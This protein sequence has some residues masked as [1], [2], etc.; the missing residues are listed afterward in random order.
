[1]A[2]I[3]TS[4]ASVIAAENFITS[5]YDNNGTNLYMAVGKGYGDNPDAATEDTTANGQQVSGQP[6][7]G[8]YDDYNRWEDE[9]NPPTPTDR[10][11]NIKSFLTNMIGMKKIQPANVMLVVPR[12]NWAAGKTYN[13]LQPA[14]I[15]GKR[16]QDYYCLTTS[17]QGDNCVWVCVGKEDTADTTKYEPTLSYLETSDGTLE[18]S[19]ETTQP[20]HSVEDENKGYHYITNNTVKCADG[21][22]WKFLY[23]ITSTMINAGLLLDNWMPVPYSHHGYDSLPSE[24]TTTPSGATTRV[25]G[26]LTDKQVTYG[27]CNANRT[28]GAYRVLV[29]CTLA[30]EGNAI[31]YSSIYR[32][33]GLLVDPRANVTA[34]TPTGKNITVNSDNTITA[35]ANNNAYTTTDTYSTYPQTVM[36]ARLTGEKYAASEVDLRYNDVNDMMANPVQVIYLENKKPMMREESQSEKLEIILV[37]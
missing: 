5:I 37:F 9:F 11:D 19:N 18:A 34:G 36:G 17:E 32:Q 15:S 2:A 25:A 26:T 33:V 22:T 12:N 24:G 20:T 3:L 30:D 29:T 7:S 14:A 31:P 6:V 16:A 8:K 1:M 28:L 13:M 35:P 4:N 10:I 21:Y 23:N 27:D